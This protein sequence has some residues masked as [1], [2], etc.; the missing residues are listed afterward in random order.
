MGWK[1]LAIGGCLGSLFGGTLGGIFGA[2]LGN[3]IEK[4][5]TKG[6]RGKSA[7]A[8]V[9]S[10][11]R[12]MIFLASVAAMLAKLAKADGHVSQIEIRA[13]EHAFQRLGFS[14]AARTYAIGVFRRAKDDAH[15]IY[16]YAAEFTQAVRSVE[17][18]ELFYELLWDLACADG[19]VTPGEME[20]LRNI[21]RS[22]AIRLQ[23][24]DIFARERLRGPY[25]GRRET[26]PPRDALAEAYELLGVKPTASNDEVK[27]AYRLKAKKYHPDALKAQG[28]P[29]EMVKKATEMMA[30]I[31]AA[32]TEIEKARGM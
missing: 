1:G 30:K 15:S 16:E 18:R 4:E 7:F 28:L 14:E 10:E 22:L 24:F 12:E 2:L 25:G 26:Q 31:N 9:S 3:K 17:V 13:V 5:M 6:S 20:I 29:D 11:K 23:W 21:P 19:T 8:S 32:W 27:K